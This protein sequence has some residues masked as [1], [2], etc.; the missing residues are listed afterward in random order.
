MHDSRGAELKVGD[1]VLIEAEITNLSTGGDE[2]F[3]CVDVKV[4]TPDQ[5]TK[6]AVMSP[7]SFSA[8]STKMLTKIGAAILLLLAIP[9]AVSA[10]ESES[11]S[12]RLAKLES[13]NAAVQQ[14]LNGIS[15]MQARLQSDVTDL[16]ESLAKTNEKLDAAMKLLSAKGAMFTPSTQ[17]VW[18]RGKAA[19]FTSTVTEATQPA[20][21]VPMQMSGYSMMGMG[22][23]SCANGS[24][25]SSGG[26]GRGLLGRRR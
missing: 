17:D 19:T 8:L 12:E 18:G 4:V 5:P 9:L 11:I 1:R 7:P 23:G 22:A 14:Q 21:A 3:C 20:Q 6:A 24:C 26:M 25:G 15:S 16:K 2:N 13:S 10:G